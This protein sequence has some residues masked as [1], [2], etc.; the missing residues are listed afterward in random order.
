MTNS[1]KNNAISIAILIAV[2]SPMLVHFI[3]NMNAGISGPDLIYK[4]I[5]APIGLWVIWAAPQ[6]KLYWEF[7]NESDQDKVTE[8]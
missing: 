3:N 6:G 1:Q 4:I 5:Y 2:M 8:E 7:F